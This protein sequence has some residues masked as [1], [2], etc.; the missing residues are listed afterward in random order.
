MVF[1]DKMG[2][3]SNRF[4]RLK[5]ADGF[6]LLELLIII[7]ILSVM[8]GMAMIGVR[9]ALSFSRLQSYAWQMVQDIRSCQ[10]DAVATGVYHEVRFDVYRPNYWI[11]DGRKVVRTVNAAPDIVYFYGVL[12]LPNRHLRFEPTGNV[13][14]SGTIVLGDAFT[15]RLRL[16]IYLQTGVVV[17]EDG[18]R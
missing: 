10:Q 6:T 7:L 12:G 18:T 9:R 17:V 11:W 8:M 5:Q 13:S 3:E 4:V 16:T 15:D 1:W 14:E 2:K